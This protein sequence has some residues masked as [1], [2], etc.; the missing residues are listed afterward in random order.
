MSETEF[1]TTRSGV[2]RI[3]PSISCTAS[4]GISFYCASK[5]AALAQRAKRRC[6]MY[7]KRRKCVRKSELEL[8]E[9][10][11]HVD[12]SVLQNLIA[13]RTIYG[14]ICQSFTPD[15]MKQALSTANNH[16]PLAILL[17]QDLIYR[18]VKPRILTPPSF[19]VEDCSESNH[20]NGGGEQKYDPQSFE[21]VLSPCSPN[22]QKKSSV[23][24][25][26]HESMD[27]LNKSI[28]SFNDSCV[29]E[30]VIDAMIQRSPGKSPL[31]HH[32]HG[33]G[34]KLNQLRTSLEMLEL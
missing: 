9:P 6:K 7:K 32:Q 16:G 27:N 31:Q 26:L 23:L 3:C 20:V 24:E 18:G 10:S 33:R 8:D 14:D 5:L 15:E 11:E 13:R 21:V 22:K 19:Y 12:E 34:K 17:M 4:P 1:S 28:E 30:D 25:A 2:D 29:L